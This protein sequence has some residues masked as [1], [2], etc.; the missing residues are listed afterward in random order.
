MAA[1]SKVVGKA[2]SCQMSGHVAY[3]AQQLAFY[4]MV[5]RR[6]NKQS[7]MRKAGILL[8]K[9]SRN[10]M[11][12]EKTPRRDDY[13][14]F[15]YSI[16][17]G[18]KELGKE[19]YDK[20]HYPEIDHGLMGKFRSQQEKYHASDNK[21]KEYRMKMEAEQTT[22][23]EA[24]EERT[25]RNAHV[26]S[27]RL[28]SYREEPTPRSARENMEGNLSQQSITDFRILANDNPE[29]LDKWRAERA[30]KF[31]AKVEKP[32][33]PPPKRSV[34]HGKAMLPAGAY[35]E[36]MPDYGDNKYSPPKPHAKVRG[37]LVP[38]GKDKA[39]DIAAMKATLTDLLG[40]WDQNEK[41]L[42]RQEMAMN[43]NARRKA[44]YE[45]PRSGRSTARSGDLMRS[46]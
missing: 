15:D 20:W 24:A 42:K 19:S 36:E 44:S 16:P 21:M 32:L 13:G 1:E 2:A 33:D 43:L 10:P 29:V 46:P 5:D 25:V 7:A 31:L 27:A 3:T 9:P 34:R 8:Q 26:E 30:A 12:A 22:K 37:A 18:R 35:H 45:A 28:D 23:Y 4:G 39:K 40:S 41:E 11:R 14:H 17:T 6:V 38:H